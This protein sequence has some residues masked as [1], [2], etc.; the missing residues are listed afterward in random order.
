MIFSPSTASETRSECSP[1]ESMRMA[2]R[3]P[4]A[5]PSTNDG[6][7]ASR[8]NSPEN[9]PGPCSTIGRSWPWPSRPVMRMA[10]DS[11]TNIPGLRSPVRITCSP[12]R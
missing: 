7:D 3:F 4:S 10:P 1:S 5:M 2:S 8:F 6:R 9:M 11:T 12:S